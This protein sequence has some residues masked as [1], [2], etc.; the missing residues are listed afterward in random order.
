MLESYRMSILTGLNAEQQEAVSL[1]GGPLLVLAG[2]G[3]G[4][5][6]VLTHRVAWTI[7]EKEIICKKLNDD[8]KR[9]VKK[10]LMGGS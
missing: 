1:S 9:R 2:A 6:K 3:S 4:K 10:I 7:K 5:T 8:W